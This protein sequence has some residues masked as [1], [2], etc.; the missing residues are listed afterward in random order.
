MARRHSFVRMVGCVGAVCAG[1]FVA[2]HAR[3]QA[4]ATNF[5]TYQGRLDAAGVPAN[6]TH[7][8]RV[9]V[10]NAVVG[11]AP[12]GLVNCFDH[13]T[14][15]NGLFTLTF[16]PGSVLDGR[17][18]WL[19]IEVR[20]DSTPA[21]CGSGVW[22]TLF[23]RQAVTA[24]PLASALVLPMSETV[25]SPAAST[26]SIFNSGTGGTS[27]A[28]KGTVG[29]SFHGAGVY[30]TSFGNEA[31]YGV[32]GENTSTNAL[33]AGT[34]GY[35]SSAMGVL[36]TSS[37]T[38]GV[39]VRGTLDGVALTGNSVGVQGINA[40]TGTNARGVA[41]HISATT[42]GTFAAGVYGIVESASA[43]FSTGVQGIH[44]GSGYGVRG[45]SA[46]DVGI[47]GDGRR[48]GVE[49]YALVNA[50][51]TFGVRGTNGNAA[52]TGV[53]G[54]HTATTGTA[55]GVWGTT[56]SASTGA[57]GVLGEVLPSVVGGASAG[58]KGINHGGVGAGHGVLGEHTGSGEGMKGTS[59]GGI[60]VWGEGPQG[61]VAGVAL[62]NLVTGSFGV[63][64]SNPNAFGVGVLG[65]HF[66]TSGTAAG[67]YGTTSSNSASATGVLG[68]VQPAAPGGFSAG[69]RGINHG[70]GGNGVGVFGRQD[71]SGY[72]VY[73]E[74]GNAAGYAGYFSG[75][76]NVT[77]ALNVG[78]MLTKGSGAFKIDHPLDPEHKFLQH[79]FVESPDMMNIYNGVV[80]TDDKGYATVTMPEWFGALNQ[81]FRYQLTIVDEAD[82]DEFVLAK[83]VKGIA[84]NRFTLR[85]SRGGV[86]VSWQVTGVR[87]DAFARDF[88]IRT[89]EAKSESERGMFLYP[90]GFGFGEERRIGRV[91]M[92]PA[93]N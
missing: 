14:V 11:G 63:R 72:G 16:H 52:G 66:A 42:P 22:T 7:D 69:V 18:L 54:E 58:V 71:G 46:N 83:V 34:G 13:V 78:G 82:T 75:R 67:V 87:H 38:N 9:T 6:G 91:K 93:G 79:S 70:T 5:M 49:G 76:V 57:V 25:S 23:P 59:A 85:A 81:D 39:G 41:G 27:S 80:T 29:S 3:A 36:G 26:F 33:S 92:D 15:V 19:E 1:L 48:G 60:G 31:S 28:V 90:Q 45:S 47:A 44:N 68:E 89:E 43:P 65:D 12:I 88:P 86:R 21:N 8:I 37:G 62:A 84:D 35:S 73:G 2:G 10:Y 55:A 32:F 50:A 40:S 24:A 61:G 30:G 74:V 20:A 17:A 64:G 4:P 53:Q 56:L 77:G 51:A